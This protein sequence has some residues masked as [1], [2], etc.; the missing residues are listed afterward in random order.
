MKKLL[1]YRGLGRNRPEHSR[2]GRIDHRDHARRRRRLVY[3]DRL[4][5]HLD[6]VGHHAG[7]GKNPPAPCGRPGVGGCRL[8]IVTDSSPTMGAMELPR[9]PLLYPQ[10]ITSSG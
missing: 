10:A 9:F 3:R 2:L 6:E 5:H 4:H 1:L 8:E 7:Y